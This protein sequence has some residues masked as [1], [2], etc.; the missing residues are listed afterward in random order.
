M[1]YFIMAKDGGSMLR[2]EYLDAAMNVSRYFSDE[3]VISVGNYSGTF[4]EICDPYCEINNFLGYFKVGLETFFEN[5]L[6]TFAQQCVQTRQF[7]KSNN[8]LG[9]SDMVNTL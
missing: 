6:T 4:S 9:T 7:S 2:P 8:I 3:M 5:F 1:Y